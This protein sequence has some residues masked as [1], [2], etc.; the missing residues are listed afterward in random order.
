MDSPSNTWEAL[1]SIVIQ[2]MTAAA[3]T[4]WIELEIWT[5]IFDSIISYSNNDL[6]ITSSVSW[7]LTM[8]NYE[9]IWP[10]AKR[11]FQY[12]TI[13]NIYLLYVTSCFKKYRNK[14]DWFSEKFSFRRI[15]FHSRTIANI[16]LFFKTVML[17]IIVITTA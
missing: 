10:C 11:F 8:H 9:G 6:H 5:R 16:Y 15:S 1:V 4:H 14:K 3:T 13:F 7:S 2:N 12:S 17:K